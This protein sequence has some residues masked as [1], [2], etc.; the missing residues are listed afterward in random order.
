MSNIQGA[1][2][3]NYS[4]NVKCSLFLCCNL[5]NYIGRQ[6]KTFEI[7]FVL[8]SYKGATKYRKPPQKI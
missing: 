6:I 5:T 1:D 3:S 7:S 2:I 4:S 8:P